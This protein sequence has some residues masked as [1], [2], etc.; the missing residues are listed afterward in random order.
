M[1]NKNQQYKKNEKTKEDNPTRIHLLGRLLQT[2][3]P[4]PAEGF[5]AD[6]TAEKTSSPSRARN[7][8]IDN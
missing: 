7:G 8:V 1:T 2:E 6:M 3:T 4:M 5:S